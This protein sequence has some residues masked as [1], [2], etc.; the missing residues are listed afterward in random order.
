MGSDVARAENDRKQQA[1]KRASP[2]RNV[3]QALA[4]EVHC[5]VKRFVRVATEGER[6]AQQQLLAL[7][8]YNLELAPLHKRA[9]LVNATV[10]QKAR[11]FG[12]GRTDRNLF[13]ANSR[14]KR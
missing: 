12:I 10:N 9:H 4:D 13:K 2:Q 14:G 3:L 11:A 6:A 7:E 8:I 5:V 1:D